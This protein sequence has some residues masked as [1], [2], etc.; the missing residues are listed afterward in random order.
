MI[1]L[2]EI[3]FLQKLR[4]PPVVIMNIRDNIMHSAS[5]LFLST[6]DTLQYFFILSVYQPFTYFF[7]YFFRCHSINCSSMLFQHSFL[8]FFLIRTVKFFSRLQTDRCQPSTRKTGSAVDG[9]VMIFPVKYIL[10]FHF[11]RS[12][13]SGYGP[14]QIRIIKIFSPI[15]RSVPDKIP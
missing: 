5:P 8:L 13:V 11:H 2:C 4:K 15:I 14:S 10:D 1:L 12:F 7:R 9:N 6:S 3:D